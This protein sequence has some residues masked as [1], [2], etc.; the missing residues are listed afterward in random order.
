M[1]IAFISDIHED[2]ESLQKALSEIK[3]T[4]VDQ[5]FCLGDIIGFN[6]NAFENKKTRNASACIKVI[7]NICTQTVAGNHDHFIIRKTTQNPEVFT[8][9]PDWYEL[10]PQKRQEIAGNVLWL[11]EVNEEETK[12]SESEKEFIN[13]LPEFLIIQIDNIRILLSH[14]IYP[15]FTGSRIGFP[16]KMEDLNEHFNFM[17]K[18]KITLSFSGH[19]HAPGTYMTVDGRIKLINYGLVEIEKNAATWISGPCIAKNRASSGLLLFDTEKYQLNVI[20]I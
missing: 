3:K 2:I 17:K 20:S 18:N 10:D 8:Y 12:L 7:K 19:G 4:E 16:D 9:P 6:S 1:L 5:I 14:Y 15:D 11:Y 13:S